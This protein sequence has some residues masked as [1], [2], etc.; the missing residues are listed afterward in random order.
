MFVIGKWVQFNKYQRR[1]IPELFVA[2]YLDLFK[3][4]LSGDLR[5]ISICF[6][7]WD[8]LVCH[9]ISVCVC[10]CVYLCTLQLRECESV[11]R[12]LTLELA[13]KS[14]TAIDSVMQSTSA[15]VR[16]LTPGRSAKHTSP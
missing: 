14:S 8:Y 15:S 5:G 6:E 1:E 10:V 3:F 12:I 16:A 13:S 7:L 4:L 2:N 9:L 11:I